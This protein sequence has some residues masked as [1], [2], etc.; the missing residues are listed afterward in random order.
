M[1]SE[2]IVVKNEPACVDKPSVRPNRSLKRPIST[3]HHGESKASKTSSKRPKSLR[4][5]KRVSIKS[6]PKEVQVKQEPSTDAEDESS[7]EISH[8]CK[9]CKMRFA[10]LR[11]L[12]KHA[13]I[14]I[15]KEEKKSGVKP[16]EEQV[17]SEPIDL[18]TY[19]IKQEKIRELEYI[20]KEAME[21]RNQ[22][23]LKASIAFLRDTDESAEQAA[24][25][26]TQERV[27]AVEPSEQRQT[28]AT[29]TTGNRSSEKKSKR[30]KNTK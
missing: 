5:N 15:D 25:R 11:S 6:E 22:S 16:K 26:E 3:Q 21:R 30:A 28:T 4:Q 1:N 2:E 14:H 12:N 8:K 27:E 9:I 13:R 7:T 18:E 29:Q 24:Q 20:E 23:M 10:N 19:R 17:K